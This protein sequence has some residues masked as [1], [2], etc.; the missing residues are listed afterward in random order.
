MSETFDAYFTALEDHDW[1]SSHH[2][3]LKAFGFFD[4]DINACSS[5]QSV[6]DAYNAILGANAA[7]TALDNYNDVMTKNIMTNF[8]EIMKLTKQ[9]DQAWHAGEYF[10]SGNYMGLVD[11]YLFKLPE[12]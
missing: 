11:Q 5:V 2:D 8:R 4:V 3:L 7:F 6:M 10:E 1:D 12:D 9:A